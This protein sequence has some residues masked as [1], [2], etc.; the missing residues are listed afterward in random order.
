MS[1]AGFS[2]QGGD[3]LSGTSQNSWKYNYVELSFRRRTTMKIKVGFFITS[4]VAGALNTC[5]YATYPRAGY[6]A[7][8]ST[9]FHDVD[10][11]V[12]IVDANT[13]AVQNFT[14][15][16]TA[17]LVFFYLAEEDSQ[18]SFLNGIPIGPLLDREYINEDLVLNMSGNQRLDG[19]NAISVW[20]AAVN[21]N[22]GSGSFVDPDPV[23]SWTF[24]NITFQS[25]VLDSFE[26]NDVVFG[27][28]G[29]EDPTLLLHLGKRYQVTILDD[30][31]HPFEVIAKG[32]SAGQ[33][34]VLLSIKTD[35]DVP[36][37]S[38]PDVA[39]TD[40]GMG[41]IAFTL[42]E[43]LYN[44]M[45]VPNK[46]PGYRCGVHISNMRGDFDVCTGPIAADLN[47][48]CRANF[49]DFGL[50]ANDWLNDNLSL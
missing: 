11:T 50:F 13:I 2:R 9:L 44:A 28:I 37:E 30:V 1:V 48:D 16:G 5:V 4:I 42:S 49:I 31:N 8:L 45:T 39:W 12:T 21:L 40:N 35:I 38:D 14:Y 25:Y 47:G 29:A 41:T 24:D 18:A 46:R 17:P 43:G 10:G 15:D 3:R 34:D 33:D 32:S 36:F 23:L 20:C 19:Y 26:P 7:E 27:S 6:R 22:F